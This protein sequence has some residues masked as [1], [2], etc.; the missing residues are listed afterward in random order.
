[1]GKYWAATTAETKAVVQCD[2]QFIGFSHPDAVRIYINDGGTYAFGF[3]RL[4]E[5]KA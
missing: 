1:M 2:H 3:W 5:R 4:K